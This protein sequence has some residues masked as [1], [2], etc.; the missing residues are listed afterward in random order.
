MRKRN[1]LAMAALSCFAFTANAVEYWVIKDGKL[2]ENIVI[3]PNE[4]DPV[5]DELKDGDATTGATY[6]HNEVHLKM[7]SWI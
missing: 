4:T 7:F 2:N 5:I 3:M 1:L 6:K